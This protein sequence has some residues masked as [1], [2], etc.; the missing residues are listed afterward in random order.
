MTKEVEKD[1]KR[2]TDADTTISPKKTINGNSSTPSTPAPSSA[3]FLS[4]T[5]PA[6][7]KS[8]STHTDIK[9]GK[10]GSESGSKKKH[11]DLSVDEG[12][13]NSGSGIKSKEVVNGKEVEGKEESKGESKSDNSRFEAFDNDDTGFSSSSPSHNDGFGSLNGTAV[14]A[15][16]TGA[17]AGGGGDVWATTT[18]VKSKA[19]KLDPLKTNISATGE[20][21]CVRGRG[22]VCVCV[23]VCVRVCECVCVC[24]CVYVCVCVCMCMCVCVCVRVYVCV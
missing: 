2:S 6:K 22:G 11:L 12:S 21:V 4:S 15:A 13:S 16:G 9:D 17:G 10:N 20:R 7:D 3:L 18:P 23:C 14:T 8:P 24:V 5:S 19:P 1:V